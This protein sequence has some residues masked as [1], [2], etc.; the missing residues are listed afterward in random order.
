M[1]PVPARPDARRSYRGGAPYPETNGEYGKWKLK[2]KLVQIPSHALIIPSRKLREPK[3][4]WSGN[5]DLSTTGHASTVFP[6]DQPP[7]F[8]VKLA[9][10]LLVNN[11]NVTTD[12][13]VLD[14]HRG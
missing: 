11:Y 5:M 6:F 10:T 7:S 4:I 12:L 13:D 9:I 1:V 3:I 2:F 14:I 8:A